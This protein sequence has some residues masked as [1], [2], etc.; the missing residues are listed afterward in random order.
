[1]DFL[2]AAPLNLRLGKNEVVK[3]C[4]TFIIF[5]PTELEVSILVAEESQHNTTAKR[6]SMSLPTSPR[7][8]VSLGPNQSSSA[9]RVSAISA[10]SAQFW[11]AQFFPA[12]FWVGRP[13]YD[14]GVTFLPCPSFSLDPTVNSK[15]AVPAE[16]VLIVCCNLYPFLS[17]FTRLVVEQVETVFCFW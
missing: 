17:T 7:S 15:P 3:H 16:G 9:R 8:L 6:I 4:T 2:P 5:P 11:V 13:D 14:A 10:F 1:M 12:P